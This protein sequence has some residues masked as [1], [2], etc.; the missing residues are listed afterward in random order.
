MMKY[1]IHFGSWIDTYTEDTIFA[2]IERARQ[3]GADAF[4]VGIPSYVFSQ[5]KVRI[6]HLCR[7]A[8]E[9]G[10]TLLFT[11][12]YP[13]DADMC[14]SDAGSRQRAVDFMINAVR[15]A[16]AC[17]VDAIHCIAYALWPARF[18]NDR[19]DAQIKSER[20]RRSIE[21][22]QKIMPVAEE[23]DVKINCEIVNRFEGFIMNTV[24]EGLDYCQQVGSTHCNLLLDTFH[25]NIEE[26]NL[27]AAIKAAAQSGRL[28]HVHVS[29]P[30]RRV[31][32]SNT[33][34]D[35]GQ[36]GAALREG[37]YDGAIVIESFLC[38]A[39]SKTYATRI[40]RNLEEP[41]TPQHK[42]CLL[43]E[44]LRFLRSQFEVL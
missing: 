16:R 1:G 20:K 24:E 14:S 34:M 21:S 35:W 3:L 2:H 28:G 42:D 25:M 26:E 23:L 17:G 13:Q 36:I 40:W 15:G 11:T 32:C 10:T 9:A 43:A 4:E 18:D 8:E 30:S 5:D 19:I 22:M 12:C 33:R 27:C 31:P 6:S 39:G 7:A 44:G 37:G 38:F 29:E 41:N